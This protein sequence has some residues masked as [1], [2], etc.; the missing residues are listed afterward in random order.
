MEN[1]SSKAV[2]LV[3][4]PAATTKRLHTYDMRA[5]NG[6]VEHCYNNYNNN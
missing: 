2:K 4:F 1:E 6:T 5:Y 3:R